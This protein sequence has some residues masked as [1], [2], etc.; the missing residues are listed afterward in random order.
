[1]FSSGRVRKKRFGAKLSTC[2][3]NLNAS[4]LKI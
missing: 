4:L 2:F 3:A 1:M